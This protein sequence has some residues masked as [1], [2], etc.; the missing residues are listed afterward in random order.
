[1]LRTYQKSQLAKAVTGSGL[2]IEDFRL[3]PGD[4]DVTFDSRPEIFSMNC[5][6]IDAEFSVFSRDGE[7]YNVVYHPSAS[8]TN[9]S[10]LSNLG[11][12]ALTQTLDSW[13]AYVRQDIESDDPWSELEDSESFKDTDEK[14]KP[15]ELDILD[16]AIDESIGHLIDTANSKGMEIT[17]ESLTQEIN[18]LKAQARKET[19]GKWLERFKGYISGKIIDWGLEKAIE[20]SVIQ[21][22][23]ESAKPVLHILASNLQM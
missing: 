19:K 9:K 11:W 10:S 12:N 7:A 16:K 4:T 15:A 17:L 6:I 18:E 22:L 14:F 20:L 1:M 8:S 3:K 23:Y 13:L 2:R 21:I 5:K